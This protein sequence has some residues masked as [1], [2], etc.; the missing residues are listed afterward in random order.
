[1]KGSERDYSK[2]LI[3]DLLFIFDSFGDFTE[4]DADRLKAI[5]YVNLN[6][7]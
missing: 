6:F 4:C 3:E 5:S 1:M 2:V 7:F